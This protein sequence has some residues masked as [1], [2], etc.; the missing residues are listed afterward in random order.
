MIPK[1]TSISANSADPPNGSGAAA[2]LAAGI[3]C[4]MVAIFAIAADKVASI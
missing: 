1:V 4:F 2:I 3:G